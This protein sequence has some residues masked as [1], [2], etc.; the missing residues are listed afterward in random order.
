MNQVYQSLRAHLLLGRDEDYVVDDGEVVL[1]DRLTGRRRPDSRY[2]H[3]L[4][5]AIEAKEGVTVHAESEVMGQI[6]VQGYMRQYRSVAGITGTA[7]ASEDEFRRAYG[8]RVTA[9]PPTHRS[10]RVDLPPDLFRSRRDKLQA[11]VDEVK[12][13]RW[14]GRPVLVGTLTVEQS[15]EISRLLTGHGVEHRVLNAVTNADEARTVREAGGRGAVTVA[16]NMAG[17]GTDIV[18]E[19]G[20]NAGITRRYVE[21]AAELLA[22]GAERVALECSTAE[23][24]GIL[25]EALGTDDGL[26]GARTRHAG[27]TATLL[28]VRPARRPAAREGAPIQTFPPRG[29]GLLALRPGE[30]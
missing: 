19:P 29:K 30:S 6:S 18:L 21:L 2:Q 11:V 26:A 4:Q 8:L 10:R 25:E 13:C 17:R 5:A 14:V 28:T 9:V 23:E 15:E 1:V 24:A 27:G 7:R 12:L 22:A 16:T 20:L 3:G